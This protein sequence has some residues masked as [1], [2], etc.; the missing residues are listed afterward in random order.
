MLRRITRHGAP[1]TIAT[2]LG[3][4]WLFQGCAGRDLTIAESDDA[5]SPG[6]FNTD[7][8]DAGAD[9]ALTLTSYC[10]ST[11]CPSPLATCS[12]SQ[13]PCDVNLMTDAKN[14]G[15]CGFECES[16]GTATFDCVSGKC[17][18]RCGE[19][20]SFSSTNPGA[21]T[22]DCNGIV[23]DDCEVALGTNDNCNGC[24]DRCPDPGKPC[25]YDKNTRIGRCGCEPGFDYC[26]SKCLDTTSDDDHCGGCDQ[27]CDPSGGG[28]GGAPP[29]NA[30][31]GCLASTCGHLK[32]DMPYGN[33]DQDLANGCETTLLS[34]DHCG[35]CNTVCAAGQT[36]MMNAK[37]VPECMC[38]PGLTLC[39]GVCLNLTTDPKNCGLCGNSCNRFPDYGNQVDTCTYGSCTHACR[40]GFGDCNGNPSDGCEVNLMSDQRN[41]GSCGNACDVLA[42]QPC[43]AGQCAVHPCGEGEGVT[44]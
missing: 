20:S 21:P 11:T 16:L 6:T 15:S 10:P 9:A 7:A 38:P 8:S 36:C 42:G 28:D 43:V 13:Y 23:D 24:G 26:S 34:N 25:I 39:N 19:V 37:K 4:M 27:A 33:C 35:D 31:Y 29:A 12:T 22:A 30:H 18:M 14:C 40:E 44:R 1:L 32:C 2:W 41:C 17:T 5:G 3:L